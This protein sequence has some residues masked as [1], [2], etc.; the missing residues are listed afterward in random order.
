MESS[1]KCL[2]NEEF[3]EKIEKLELTDLCIISKI[4][5]IDHNDKHSVGT[6]SSEGSNLLS[7]CSLDSIVNP[8]SRKSDLLMLCEMLSKLQAG[9]SEFTNDDDTKKMVAIECPYF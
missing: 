9:K 7:Q 1:S 4:R 5:N 6:K 2:S 8:E 3:L